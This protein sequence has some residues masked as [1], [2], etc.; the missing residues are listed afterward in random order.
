MII[1]IA[2]PT[3]SGKTAAAVTLAGR[4]D[5]EIISTDAMQI[6]KGM[7]IGTAKASAK[8]RS[9][10]VHH[11]IDITDPDTAMNSA[12][13]LALA[14]AA[15]EDILARGKIPVIT[16]GSGLY[17]DSLIYSSYDYSAGRTDPQLRKKLEAEAE[18]EGNVFMHEKLKL[19]DPEYASEVHPNNTKRVIRALEFFIL[20]GQKKSAQKKERIFRFEDTLYF[21]LFCERSVIYER[22]NK[23]TDSMMK[24]G[25]EDEVRKLYEAGYDKSH[26]SMQAIGYKEL[27]DYFESKTTLS[28]AVENIKRLSRNYAKRQMTWFGRNKDIY[29]IDTTEKTACQTV[30]IIEEKIREFNDNKQTAQ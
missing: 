21:G 30:R 15:A 4:I 9:E 1:S 11:L 23:R 24:N 25:L 5:G 19:A 6:Y 28:E 20:T 14:A 2:G 16:G 18:T 10:A 17:H 13:F 7:N 29:W 8:E 27:I 26:L 12:D 22:I 3:A